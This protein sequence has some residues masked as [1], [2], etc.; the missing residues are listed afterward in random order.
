[1]QAPIA[2]AAAFMGDRLHALAK[3]GILRP[4]RLVSHG[5]AAV[6]DGFTRPPFTHLECSSQMRDS[7]RSAGGVTISFPKVLQRRIV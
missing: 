4:G 5:Q 7:F 1:M 3:A 2:E 6:A